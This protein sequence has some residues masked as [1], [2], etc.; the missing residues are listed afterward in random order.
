ML[1]A[2]R[3]LWTGQIVTKCITFLAFGYLARRLGTQEY[4]A[5]EYAMGLATFAALAVDGGLSAVGVRRIAQ[6]EHSV[7]ELAAAVPAAQF[8]VALVVA[9][10]MVL[11][12][13]LFANDARAVTLVALTSVSVLI[14]P[15]KQDWLFQAEGRMRPIVAGQI[16]R[17]ATF[18]AGVMVF[19][20]S[21]ADV[22]MVGVMEIA[23][24]ALAALYLIVLQRSI[25][26]FRV[27]FAW[28]QMVDLGREARSIGVAAMVWAL[29]QYAPLAM[30]ANIAGMA[31]TAYFGAAHRLGV[32][33]VT[34]SWIYH[35][36]FYP[37]IAHRMVANPEGMAALTQASFRVAA[38]C[39][40]GL[41][42]GLTLAAE[43]LLALLF[44]EKF[45][46]AAP[47][48]AVLVWTFPVT[49]LSGHA[50]WILVAARRAR[51]M[52]A[53]QLAGGVVAIVTAPPLIA[54]FGGVGAGAAM[55]LACLV[56]WAAAHLLVTLRVRAAP[57]APCVIPTVAAMLI[58][59]AARW[60]APDPWIACAAGIAA[61]CVLALL[62]DR[63]LVPAW[64]YIMKA[65]TVGTTDST[66]V[67]V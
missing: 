34:F 56:I 1:R 27:R 22:S 29:I 4:G 24:V 64:A 19:V 36:N 52:L 62:L 6:R 61:F 11:F 58:L 47:A 53:A 10:C 33:L 30:L 2:V 57:F 20:S 26:P 23:S 59:A 37:T 45:R 8:C 7:R 14:L 49:L 32:S 38:W 41:A 43:P 51:D 12:A 63:A 18:A 13:W 42:L 55:L 60:L 25:T 17:A 67:E 46:A 44:G 39:G 50:R 21:A 40:I 35:F 31:D 9:P 15:W 66:L 3:V 28:R 48:F 54:S 16:L 5:V 65:R